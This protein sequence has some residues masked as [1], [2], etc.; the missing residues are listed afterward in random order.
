MKKITTLIL[1]LLFGTSV[2]AEKIDMKNGKVVEGKIINRDAEKVKV[3]IGDGLEVT[4]Y[5]DEIENID[6]EK[7]AIPAPKGKIVVDKDVNTLKDSTKVIRKSK[8][9]VLESDP[10]QKVDV[11]S[12]YV[13]DQFIAGKQNDQEG[14]TIKVTGKIPDGI[15]YEYYDSGKLYYETNYK[16][17]LR[18]GLEKVYYETGELLE[19]NNYQNDKLNGTSKAFYKNGIVMIEVNYENNKEHG[20]RKIYF[21]SGKLKREDNWDNG[22]RLNSTVYD[23]SGNINSKE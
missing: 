19:E 8:T 6:G 12:F 11:Y 5:L 13:D 17:N 7:A 20:I 4:Y 1:I 14:N 15:V 10:N 9:G 21:E 2:S 16:N 18:D 23:E 22:K 3:N